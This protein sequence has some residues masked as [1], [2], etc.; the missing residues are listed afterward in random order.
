MRLISSSRITSADAIGPNSVTSC[1]GRRIDH[2]EADDFGRL[3]VGAPLDARELGVADRREDHAEER[4][5]DAGHAAQQ[6]VAGVDL[7]LA[8]LVVGGRDFREQDD[9]GDGL[10]GVVA[11]ERLAAFGEDG[12]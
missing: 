9:V 4:L 2:L 12:A 10:R 7:P 5:A 1:A 3:Q 6:Q 11:D 8:P